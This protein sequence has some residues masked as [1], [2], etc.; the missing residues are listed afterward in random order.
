MMGKYSSFDCHAVNKKSSCH[1]LANNMHKG[2]IENKH[3][4][5]ILI[6]IYCADNASGVLGKTAI[7][8]AH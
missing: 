3:G 4:T 5:Y 8:K 7:L 2:G 6:T 1:S